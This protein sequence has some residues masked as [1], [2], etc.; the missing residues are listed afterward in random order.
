MKWIFL[1]T[2]IVLM[3]A[4]GPAIA[5][6]PVP[7]DQLLISP[8][9]IDSVE[10]LIAESFPVQVFAHVR[11]IVGDGCSEA[12]PVQQTRAG[13]TITIV[14]NRQRP[15]QA[16]CTQIAKVFDQNIR[17]VG[18]FP[19]GEYVLKVNAVEKKFRVD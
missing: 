15:A 3:S 13:N 19:P 9:Q 11:G 12:L 5:P 4:C 14:I 10:V 16:I 18:D 17:L 8:I 6:A 7:T 1:A 2:W